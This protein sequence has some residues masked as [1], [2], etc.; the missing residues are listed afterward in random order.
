MF[1]QGHANP[2]HSAECRNFAQNNLSLGEADITPID[3]ITRWPH[4]MRR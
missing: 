2:V 3:I 1:R 4:G